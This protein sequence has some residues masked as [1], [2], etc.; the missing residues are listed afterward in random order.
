MSGNEISDDEVA[1]LYSVFLKFTEAMTPHDA[2]KNLKLFGANDAVIAAVRAKH[3]AESLRI[4]E[5]DEPPS[6]FLNGRPT[7]YTGPDMAKDKNWPALATSMER[8]FGKESLK[9]VDESSTKIVALLD[10]PKQDTFRTQGLVVGF[11]Q[12]GKTTN[13]TAVMAKAADRGYKLFIVLSGI[14]NAL[15]RQTQIRLVN[16][17]VAANPGHWHQVTSEVHDFTPP[18]N[19]KAFFAVTGQCLLLV[20]KKNATVLRKLNKWLGSAG[21]YLNDC[22]TLIIDDEADQSTVATEKINP[23]LSSILGKFPRVGYIGYTATPFANLLIDPSVEEDFYPRDFVVNLPQPVGYHGPEVLFGRALLEG[24]DPADLPGGYDMIREV[25]DDEVDDLKPKS[26]RDAAY[27]DPA[28][29]PSLRAAVEWFW[30]ATAARRVRGGG[31]PHST[32]LV[33]TTTETR[34]HE[35]FMDPL[36]ALRS[37]T[38]QR[39]DSGDSALMER[40]RATWDDE[41]SRVPA[42]EFGEVKV[43]FGDVLVELRGAVRDTRVIIDNYRSNDRLNYESGPV[44]AIAVGG[45]TLSRGL[46]L[47][48]LVSSFF[49]RAVSAYDT[50]LQMG[51]WFGYRKHYADLPRIWMTEELADWFNHLATVEADM[52]QDINRYMASNETPLTFAVRLRSHPKLSITSKAKMTSA[53]LAHAAY[54]GQLVES[55]YFDVSEAGRAQLASNA[56][57]ARALVAAAAEEGVRDPLDREAALFTDVP[58][59]NIIDF[60]NSYEFHEDSAD[61]DRARLV[62]YITKR[63]RAGALGRWSVGVIGNGKDNTKPCSLGSGVE[64]RMVKRARLGHSKSSGEE[65]DSITTEPDSGIDDR[66]ADIKTLS[67]RR[68]ETIDLILD[69]P[70]PTSHPGILE[71]RQ[72]QR[73]NQGLLLIYPIEPE[74]DTGTEGRVPLAAPTEDVVIGVTLL[75]PEPQQGEKDSDVEYWSADLSNVVVEVED[76]AVL[77]Q[78]DEVA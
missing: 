40:L 71:L 23:L 69:G 24:E 15:R 37:R 30:L 21:E 53:V 4:R 2:V 5:L 39:L 74:S 11:V 13:F 64:V 20:V 76:D 8:G 67:S 59:G 34:V 18:P 70:V 72:Q 35:A 57:A 51:R 32:M 10:H 14:H 45:S 77:E 25:P 26:R 12:S 56:A 36:L 9:S 46:T 55:R 43:P 42:R 60:L 17:L 31:N 22:P 41:T 29:T 75:F 62:G 66:K 54:G 61:G 44:T 50:L 49:V 1:H 78:D 3:D 7:W 48:G 58:Y 68:D 19:P 73:P 65:R 52:R 47:E 6:I 27:F 38:L 63:V 16:D 33:H 28:I